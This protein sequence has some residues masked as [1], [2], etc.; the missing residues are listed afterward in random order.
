MTMPKKLLLVSA[1]LAATTMVEAQERHAEVHLGVGRTLFGNDLEDATHGNFGVGYSIDRW[2]IELMANEYDTEAQNSQIAQDI[3]GS[4]FRIDQFYHFSDGNWRPYVSLGAG[5]QRLSPEGGEVSKQTMLNL[6]IGFKNR[7][8][9]DWEWRTEIRAFNSLDEH[10]TDVAFSTG[11]SFLFGHS[12]KAA[13]APAPAPAPVVD[14]DSDGDGVPDSRDKCPDT[15]RRYKVNSDGCPQEMTESVST[16]LKIIFEF[17]SAEVRDEYI[18]EVRRVAEFMNQYLNT[19][20]TIEG[21]TDSVGSDAYNKALS[22][23]RAN[24][25]R[26][27]LVNRL[28]IEPE[29]VNAVGFGE[30]R[31]VA[32]NETDNGRTANRRVV[33][34]VGTDVTRK[35][36]R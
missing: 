9:R 30:E 15:P 17:D 25:V 29:R 19:R 24:A 23:R 16:D 4:Q 26:D 12:S 5:Q 3:R 6:G 18:P 27:V 8:A 14:P 11:I 31:P 33:A 21:H 32:D 1:L 36:T 13:P 2:S 7:F 34:E 28:D 35:V 20:V 22:Q 10:F